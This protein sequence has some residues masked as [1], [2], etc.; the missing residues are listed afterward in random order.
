MANFKLCSFNCKNFNGPLKSEYICTLL[1]NCDFLCIQEHHLFENELHKFED[2]CMGQPPVIYTGTSAMDPHMFHRGRK[3]GGTA[4]LWK[5]NIR[6]TVTPVKT[7]SNR[8]SAVTATLQN[9]NRIII[10]CVY[11]PCDE[12]YRGNNLTEYQ[13]IL[14][15]ISTISEEQ[16]IS[17]ICIAGDFNTDISRR[18][19][20][21]DELIQFCNNENLCLLKNNCVSSVDYTFE[22]A[23]ATRSC[24][25]HIIVTQNLNDSVE[26]YTCLFDVN[27]AS[28]HVP[29]LAEFTINCEYLKSVDSPKCNSTLW[30]MANLKDIDNYKKCLDTKLDNFVSNFMLNV[31][32]CRDAHCKN[33]EHASCL[34]DLYG[35]IVRACLE[36]SKLTIPQRKP[37]QRQGK[38]SLPGFSEYVKSH[39]DTALEW[40]RLWKMHGSPAQGYVAEMRKQT[41]KQYH[42]RVKMVKQKETIIRS[43][44]MAQAIKNGKQKDL[45]QCV[46]TFKKANYLP[47]SIDGCNDPI[48][49][50]EIFADKYKSLYNSVP[51]HADEFLNLKSQNVAKIDENFLNQAVFDVNHVR[52][53]ISVLKHN[54]HDGNIGLYSDHVINGTEKLH[55]LL[56][57]LFNGMLVHG[58]SI[59]DMLLGTLTPIVKDKRAKLSN[60][61]NFRSICLQNV[62]CKLMDI[63]IL[64]KESKSLSTSDM[65]FGFKPEVST[66]LAS[67]MFLETTDYYVKKGGRVFALALD[68]SKAFDRVNYLKLFKLLETRKLNPVYIRFLLDNYINQKL[69]VTYDNNSSDWFT[70]SNGVKQGAVL[71]PTLFSVYMDNLLCKITDAGLG[72]NIGNV[73]CGIIGYADDILLLAPTVQSLNHM[74][75]ICE[76]YADEYDIKFNGAKSQLMIFGK[77]KENIDVY[78]CEQKVKVVTEMKYL[79]NTISNSIHDP[80]VHHVKN[81]FICKVNSFLA[82]FNNVSSYVKN[83][84]FQQYCFSL[85][86][87]NLCMLDHNSMNDLR[88]AWR[89]AIRRL[90]KLP[91][92][93]HCKLLPDI[94]MQMPID[95]SIYKRFSKHFVSGLFHKNKSVSGVFKSSLFYNSRLSNNFRYI[96]KHC[97]MYSWNVFNEPIGAMPEAVIKKFNKSSHE[98]NIRIAKQI[99]ELC[100]RRDRYPE[101]WLLDRSDVDFILKFLCTE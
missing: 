41:R 11:M 97:D 38:C 28:D 19:P 91:Y 34:E 16:C 57:K 63:M 33:T 100:D 74:V 40:H 77:C 69:R 86:G 72:C 96:A 5:G 95:V 49:I 61:E 56:V 52:K 89:K 42:N 58:C 94:A 1:K 25:D 10:F 51:Y 68:A 67:S 22:S 6:W 24:I 17:T 65:Q 79:G 26:Q 101:E 35:A 82:N 44:R 66:S 9:N 93:T 85:Y 62:L 92:T 12:M 30:Y 47:S 20:H 99:R 13:N 50:S 23:F 80:L 15:E 36:S 46:R 48:G 8:L 70:V 84:L 88:V 32:G 64:C 4:I 3:Y 21:S 37:R 60:S 78:V 45:W 43:E 55:H 76:A 7:S 39:K 83:S 53:A 87:S 29:V 27:N 73:C 18:S 14:D 31:L 98:D 75:K 81:D 90:W 54:K 2:L 71:S 59:G